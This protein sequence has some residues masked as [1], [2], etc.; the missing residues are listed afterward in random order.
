MREGFYSKLSVSIGVKLILASVVLH[1]SAMA[2]PEIKFTG[3]FPQDKV[4]ASKDYAQLDLAQ[5]VN[6]T[7]DVTLKTTP[8]GWEENL[9]LTKPLTD[10][11]VDPPARLVDRDCRNVIH[12]NQKRDFLM[13]CGNNGFNII[14]INVNNVNLAIESTS[15]LSI[16]ADPMTQELSI[17]KCHGMAFS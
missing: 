1:Q 3:E 6:G 4:Y 12:I 15:R 13:M 5:Y 17:N 7:F 8:P 16:K 11:F 2:A 10:L 9:R 14:Y